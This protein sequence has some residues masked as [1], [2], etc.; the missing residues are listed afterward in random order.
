MWR[1]SNIIAPIVSIIAS[2]D[3]EDP[4]CQNDSHGGNRQKK[5]IQMDE[6]KVPELRF[7]DVVGSVLRQFELYD[8]AISMPETKKEKEHWRRGYACALLDT[9]NITKR[10]WDELCNGINHPKD[11]A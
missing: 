5:E 1:S 3:I 9:R 10:E 8:D 6:R 11:R 4:P 2:L 7:N